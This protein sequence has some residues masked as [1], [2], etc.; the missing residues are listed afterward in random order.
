MLQLKA[1]FNG[2]LLSVT[3]IG[4]T[5]KRD[6]VSHLY[7]VTFSNVLKHVGD[8]FMI[9]HNPRDGTTK[10]IALVTAEVAARGINGD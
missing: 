6:G 7:E 2:N 10:L 3:Q 9:S 1:E 5:G 4:N 8:K